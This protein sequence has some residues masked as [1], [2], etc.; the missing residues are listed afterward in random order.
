M[1]RSRHSFVVDEK[2]RRASLHAFTASRSALVE[3][4][5]RPGRESRRALEGQGQS[6]DGFDVNGLVAS[7]A[8]SQR[9][10]GET[11]AGPSNLEYD[12]RIGIIDQE[13]GLDWCRAPMER[14]ERLVLNAYLVISVCL[15]TNKLLAK[16]P[17]H[18]FRAGILD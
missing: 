12:K 4:R 1:R 14:A 9:S 16:P 11:F 7:N 6:R 17:V 13:P 3:R 8:I 5:G 10:D 2:R 15:S 18:G